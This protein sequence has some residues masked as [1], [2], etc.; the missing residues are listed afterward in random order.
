MRNVSLSLR[1]AVT[2]IARSLPGQLLI[3]RI[4]G[5][6]VLDRFHLSDYGVYQALSPFLRELLHRF[7]TE[8]ATWK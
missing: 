5:Q 6:V 4:T 2:A 7:L 8:L 3:S 1:K